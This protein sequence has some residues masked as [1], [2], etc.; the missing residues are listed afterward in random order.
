[1]KNIGQLMKQAQE[2]QAQMAAMQD[3]LGSIFVEGKAGGG[4]VEVTLNCKNDLKKLKIDPSLLNP[5][6]VEILEDLLIAAFNDAK[7]KVEAR[8]AE[9]MAKI[10]SGLKLPGGMSL[11]F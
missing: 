1:M 8:T 9:E 2:M 10:T 3:Q 4:M 11:P 7:Q 6:E 5:T